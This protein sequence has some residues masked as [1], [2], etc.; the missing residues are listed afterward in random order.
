[1]PKLKSSTAASALVGIWTVTLTAFIVAA[2]YLAHDLCI[3]L[4]LAALLSLDDAA[5]DAGSVHRAGIAEQ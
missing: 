3:P 1:M 5:A 2:L 4:A